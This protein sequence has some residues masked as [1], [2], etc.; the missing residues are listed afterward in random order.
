MERGLE[1]RVA[2]KVRVFPFALGMTLMGRK[3]SPKNACLPISVH[4]PL[5]Q[6][7]GEFQSG[8]P[9]HRAAQF[10]ISEREVTSD[11][12]LTSGGLATGSVEVAG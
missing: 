3:N 8:N 10:S 7:G 6:C 4:V 2:A 11:L 12:T 5:G 9:L 1:R